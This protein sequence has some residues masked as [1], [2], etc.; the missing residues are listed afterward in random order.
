M[1]TWDDYK[2]RILRVLTHIQAHLDEA[3]NLE[4]LAHVAC[5]SSFHFHRIFAAMTGET[6]A[7]H[8]RRLRLERAGME[9]RA[10]D[11]QVIQVALHAGYEA[12]EAFTRA[13]KAAYGISPTAFRRTTGHIAM[14]AAPS[15][16]HF[17]PGV[18][19]TTFNTNHTKTKV[20]KVITT[21]IKPMQVAY[22]RH[23]GPYENVRQTWIQLMSALSAD[24]QIRKRSKFIGIGHD[25][26]EVTPAAELRYDAC[27]T[28]D[29]EYEPK[30]PVDLQTIVGGD[31]AVVENCPVEKIKDAF[32]HLYG[33]WLARSSRELRP[34]PSFMIFVGSRDTVAP[35]KQ[36][37]DIYM[38]LQPKRRPNL[39]KEMNIEV[40]TLK[41]QR[42]A[43]LRHVG[44]YDA[45]LG[46]WLDFT[47]R[48]KQQGLPGK[49][50]VFIGV[51]M[52]NP[53]VTPPDK[54]RYDAC[55]TIDEK[56]APKKPLRFRKI[57]GGD[58]VVARNCPR[59]AIAKGY[60][61]LFYSWLP[62]SGRK[63]RKTPSFLVSVNDPEGTSP[64]FGFTDI[65]VPLEMAQPAAPKD[66]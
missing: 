58:Y 49:D 15:G 43:Y 30:Q 54:L 52:D 59:G 24:Q 56:F 10:D 39:A 46:V 51:P 28:V 5:F 65:Y 26:P 9:L 32:G 35:R 61:K 16:V 13:F 55:M 48:L 17:R 41:P 42:V 34:A 29:E 20:M 12:H 25:N 23:V 38:P 33:K 37:V 14:L 63:A 3:M 22:L 57:A 19:L 7:D 4:E 8:V 31:Y 18:P 6:L 47:T 27:I 53:K 62:G 1:T 66:V 36:R 11:K 45:T 2:V 50:S 60:E 64:T 21:K 44:P 40:T